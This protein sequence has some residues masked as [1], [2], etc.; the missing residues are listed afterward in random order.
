MDLSEEDMKTCVKID[1][2]H[3]DNGKCSHF[4][5]SSLEPMCYCPTGYSLNHEDNITCIE[6]LRCKHGYRFSEHDGVSCVD[7]DECSEDPEICLNG[8]CVNEK[9]SYSCQCDTGYH[10]IESNRTCIDIDECIEG[11]HHCSH[12]CLNL[13]GKFQ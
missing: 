6:D 2:C 7:I 3:I 11:S 1:P 5:D 9:G 10:F 13:P 4:C 8:V 12:R